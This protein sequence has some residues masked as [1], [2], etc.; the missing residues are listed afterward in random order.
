MDHCHQPDKY[1]V[2]VLY[3][4]AEFCSQFV[5]EPQLM[6]VDMSQ[7]KNYIWTNKQRARGQWR[8]SSHSSESQPWFSWCWR[9]G[10]SW[11]W[12]WWWCQRACRASLSACWQDRQSCQQAG[13]GDMSKQG[14]DW[15]PQDSSWWRHWRWRQAV[16]ELNWIDWAFT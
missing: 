5:N 16:T 6:L 13:D 4:A 9:L 2:T 14:S 1:I 15:L 7:H 8:S 11:W 10:M 12:W 3:L